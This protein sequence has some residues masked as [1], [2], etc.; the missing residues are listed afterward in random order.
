MSDLWSVTVAVAAVL[1]VTRHGL[2]AQVT[3]VSEQAPRATPGSITQSL[4]IEPPPAQTS[5]GTVRTRP[6]AR[7]APSLSPDP[8]PDCG[9]HPT[10]GDREDCPLNFCCIP[11][12]D[13]HPT[14]TTPYPF[15][16]PTVRL[17]PSPL[18]G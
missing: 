17:N 12:S 16:W 10:I 4:A 9:Q 15:F 3:H 7:I 11:V 2:P 18:A 1:C 8:L 13:Q 5:G 6:R 14:P